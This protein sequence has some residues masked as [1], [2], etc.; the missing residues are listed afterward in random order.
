MEDI[1]AFY[2][3]IAKTGG[4]PQVNLR[5]TAP[6]WWLQIR[7]C[8]FGFVA[9]VKDRENA[10]VTDGDVLLHKERAEYG[11]SVQYYSFR[12]GRVVGVGKVEVNEILKESFIQ[13]V[14]NNKKLPF[15]CTIGRISK[16]GNVD[17]KYEPSKYD[18]FPLKLNPAD[19]GVDDA[20]VFLQGLPVEMVNPLG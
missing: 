5:A 20:G 12:D 8:D 6:G 18:K 4:M 14:Q 10:E 3:N 19:L 7:V 15:G 11:F 9:N 1:R 16:N 13:F 2:I 17:V